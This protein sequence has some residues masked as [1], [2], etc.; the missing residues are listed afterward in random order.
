MVPKV[1]QDKRDDV[2][3]QSDVEVDPE[4]ELSVILNHRAAHQRA[5]HSPWQGAQVQEGLDSATELVWN[6]FRCC[7]KS[8]II[9]NRHRK[10]S[11]HN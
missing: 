3:R 9:S 11:G 5:E 1:R 6:Q 10:V 2:E 7:G 4:S 8:A